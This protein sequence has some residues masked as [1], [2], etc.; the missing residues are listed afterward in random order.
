MDLIKILN[1]ID[2]IDGRVDLNSVHPTRLNLLVDEGLIDKVDTGDGES[3]FYVLSDQAK[4]Y[5]KID[6]EY[7]SKKYSIKGWSSSARWVIADWFK[8]NKN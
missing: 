2:F 3:C 7:V 4:H 6:A 1:S 5:I 8:N